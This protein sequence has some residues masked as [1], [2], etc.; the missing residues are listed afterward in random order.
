MFTENQLNTSLANMFAGANDTMKKYENRLDKDELN[1]KMTELEKE[2]RLQEGQDKT[3]RKLALDRKL[4]FLWGETLP[5]DQKE[6]YR[7]DFL[8]SMQAGTPFE[9]ST[10]K[11]SQ[12][13]QPVG[14]QPSSPKSPWDMFGPDLW[15]TRIQGG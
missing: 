4:G 2:A 8:K 14:T 6:L 5:P 9:F 12:P 3:D 13:N 1:Q 10:W 7:R 11:P 15:K